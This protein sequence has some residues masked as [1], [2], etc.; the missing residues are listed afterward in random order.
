MNQPILPSSRRIRTQ[1]ETARAEYDLAGIWMATRRQSLPITIAAVLGLGMG[2]FHFTTSPREY[3][4]TATVLIEEQQGDFDPEIGAPQPAALSDASV[5]NQVQIL[6]SLHLATE[7]A[8]DLG[9]AQNETFQNPPVSAIA[10]A[11][12]GVRDWT[13]SFFP[14]PLPQMPSLAEAREIPSFDPA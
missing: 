14:G 4:A 6:S 1:P 11:A 5:M 10:R 8:A 7:V 13:G 9:L 3:R 2:I 12:Q